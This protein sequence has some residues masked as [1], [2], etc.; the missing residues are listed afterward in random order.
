MLSRS[1]LSE[2]DLRDLRTDLSV[3]YR[4]FDDGLENLPEELEGRDDVE[5]EDRSDDWRPGS[6]SHS[7]ARSPAPQLPS[8]H[9]FPHT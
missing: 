5:T 3:T 8:S 1:T 2:A 6:Q 9:R 7:L 4:Q